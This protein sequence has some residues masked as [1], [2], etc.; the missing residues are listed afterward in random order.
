MRPVTT[1]CAL[2]ATTLVLAL[3]VG[4]GRSDGRGVAAQASPAAA[5]PTTT[6]AEN[7]AL[8]RRHVEIRFSDADLDAYD[9][10]LAPD[11]VHH[12]SLG[13]GEWQGPAEF[14]ASVRRAQDAL[15]AAG[16]TIEVILSE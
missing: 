12:R 9:A 15:D 16:T 7:E 13:P 5:C 2:I 1:V 8:A 4:L 11:Y 10:L 3:I 14:K 6:P